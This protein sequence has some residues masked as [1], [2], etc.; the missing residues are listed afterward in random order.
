MKKSILY[1]EKLE[2]QKNTLELLKLNFK[3]IKSKELNENN[4]N[5]IISIFLPMDDYYS[6]DFFSKFK[7]LRT[8]VTPTTGDIH[9]D[10]NYLKKKKIKIINLK[11]FSNQLKKIT[12]TSEFTLGLILNLTRNILGAHNSFIK[13]KVFNKYDYLLSNRMYNLGIIGLGRIGLH[14]AKRASALGFNIIYYDPF[15]SN[16]KFKKIKNFDIFLKN[17]NILSIHMHY[18]PKYFKKFNKKIFKKLKK[19]SFIINTSRGEFID[20]DDLIYCL[21]NKIISGAG[22][23]VLQNEHTKQFRSNPKT[24]KLIRFYLKNKPSNLFISPKQGGSNQS[25]WELTEKIICK[26]LINYEKNRI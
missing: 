11:K 7:N 5:Q 10:K 9:L 14:L 24:N 2:F 13:N 15:I 19:P 20:E 4:Y 23:D 1:F 26:D 6:E 3:L 17:T 25:A 18:K 21:K 22:L 12:S 16:K 8:V